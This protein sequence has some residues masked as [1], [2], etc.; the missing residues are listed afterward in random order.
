MNQLKQFP[1]H[2][3]LVLGLAKSGTAACEILTR[4]GCIVKANDLNAKSDDP[5]IIQLK[6]LGVEVVTGEHP[7]SLL[8]GIDVIVKN[9]GIPYEN[10]LIK[11]ALNQKIPVITEIELVQYLTNNQIIG[12]TGSNGKTTTTTLINEMLT[13]SNQPNKIAGNI[14]KV[15]AEVATTLEE[16][17]TMVVELSSFQLMGTE[18]FHP[19][20]AVLLNLFEAHLDYH[21]TFENYQ[22]A[23]AQIFANQDEN[24]FIIYNA[25]DADVNEM[26]QTAK[27][28]KIP[29]STKQQLT[30]GAWCDDTHIYFKDKKIIEL[31][32]IALVGKHN[33]ENIL[34]SVAACLLAGG[35]IQGIKDVL[36]TF[37]GVK[38]RLQF[39]KNHHNRL[40]YNDSKAT[41]I[42]ATTKAISAFNHPIILLAGGLDR[43]NGFDELAPY[44]QSVKALI[45]FGET[46]KK[47]EA[48]GKQVG[49]ETIIHVETMEQA[50]ANAYEHSKEHDVI[51][52]SPACASWD[53]Y[54][55]FEERGDMFIKAVHTL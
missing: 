18:T 53:Q 2:D 21:H 54:R 55:T 1:Y 48:I 15:A 52:L 27:S 10:E 36:T 13:N 42:L 44:L 38:H 16:N 39:I 22:H 41:N 50:V 26:V 34:A 23:K 46:A 5:A 8:E 40:F 32:E 49:I 11:E 31:S 33:L 35:T 4:N 19:K 24:D 25:D 14:G 37:T 20:I 28:M 12:I 3:I 29:F 51:L 30:N 45:V 9:P 7:L 47:L 43:G 6:K 17:E